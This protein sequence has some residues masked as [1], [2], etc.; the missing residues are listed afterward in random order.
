MRG[1]YAARYDLPIDATSIIGTGRP[2]GCREGRRTRHIHRVWADSAQASSNSRSIR[3]KRDVLELPAGEHDYFERKSG[4]L[5]VSQD[6]RRDVAKAL[7]AFAN[8]RGGHLVPGI[9]RRQR[10]NRKPRRPF[11]GGIAEVPHRKRGPRGSLLQGKPR[12]GSR[13]PPSKAEA[14]GNIPLSPP[15]HPSWTS[16]DHS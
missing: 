2:F 11:C 16:R 12:F 3:A 13:Y 15:S 7:S 1:H 8:S 5:F 14:A 9:N 10:S 6:F 4:A